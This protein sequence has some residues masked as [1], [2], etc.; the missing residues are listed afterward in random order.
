MKKSRT[1]INHANCEKKR[2]INH[3]TEKSKYGTQNLLDTLNHHH[4]SKSYYI[5]NLSLRLS[6][7]FTNSGMHDEQNIGID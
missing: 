2:K 7:V 1:N 4:I 6:F 3:A 5:N